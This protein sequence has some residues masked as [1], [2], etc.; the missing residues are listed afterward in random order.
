MLW[1][2]QSSRNL[3]QQGLKF[4]H[5]QRGVSIKW[6]TLAS[7]QPLYLL[8][9]KLLQDTDALWVRESTPV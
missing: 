2:I 5:I 1:G 6:G 4:N 3:S 7:C 8:L 9:Q